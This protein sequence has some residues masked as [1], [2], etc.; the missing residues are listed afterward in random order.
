MSSQ[1][2]NSPGERIVVQGGEELVVTK[3]RKKPSISLFTKD[4][5]HPP[6]LG[7]RLLF[8][9]SLWPSVDYRMPT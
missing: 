5:H 6:Q 3:Q 9:R 8:L 4:Y 1:S 2:E 7:A